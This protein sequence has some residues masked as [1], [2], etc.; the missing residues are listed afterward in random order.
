VQSVLA[1]LV[2]LVSAA[3]F[4]ILLCLERPA[5]VYIFVGGG[6]R[7]ARLALAWQVEVF[8]AGSL[9]MCIL[10]HSARLSSTYFLAY[11][12]YEHGSV[13]GSL[14]IQTSHNNVGSQIIYWHSFEGNLSLWLGNTAGL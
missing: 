10:V 4:V 6:A 12:T 2:V 8:W 3:G 5:C 1:L 13:P 9:R 11:P 7:G 14:Q